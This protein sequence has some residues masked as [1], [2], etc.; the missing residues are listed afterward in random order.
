MSVQ[1]GERGRMNEADLGRVSLIVTELA[2]NLLL[3]AAGGEVIM[4]MLPAGNR[5]RT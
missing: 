1:I 3:H 2:T 5:Q 4:R